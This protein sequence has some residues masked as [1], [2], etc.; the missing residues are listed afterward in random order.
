VGGAVVDMT[1]GPL[2]VSYG[3][4]GSGAASAAAMAR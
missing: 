4:A 2:V 3:A 1:I